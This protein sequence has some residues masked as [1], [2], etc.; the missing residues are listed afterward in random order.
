M[1][2]KKEYTKIFQRI[3]AVDDSMLDGNFTFQNIDEWDSLTH[4]TL[5]NELES[6]F[7]ILLD[8]EDILHFGGFENGMKI[9]EKYGVDF[10][11]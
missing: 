3:F 11:R 10:N 6:V 5:I 4:L 2:N 7:D 9:L 8:T 1:T